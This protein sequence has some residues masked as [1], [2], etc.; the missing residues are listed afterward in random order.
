[1]RYMTGI[2]VLSCLVVTPGRAAIL[3]DER[4]GAGP[5]VE[6]RSSG[7]VPT[8]LV[9]YQRSRASGGLTVR[10]IGQDGQDFVS[11]NN[12]L[13]ASDVQDIHLVARRARSRNARSS[14]LT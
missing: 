2:V 6:G 4:Q 8:R 12:R 9:T 11:P 1:M 3:E 10:W 14:S 5:A 7:G 13:E